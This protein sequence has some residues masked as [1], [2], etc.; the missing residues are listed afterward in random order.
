M[1]VSTCMGYDPKLVSVLLLKRDREE[2]DDPIM[3]S[4]PTPLPGESGFDPWP[5]T[6]PSGKADAKRD[7][8]AATAAA[9]VVADAVADAVDEVCCWC[10]CCCD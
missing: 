5:V 1:G 4:A 8:A 10:C 6:E 9:A 7:A 3:G 2:A